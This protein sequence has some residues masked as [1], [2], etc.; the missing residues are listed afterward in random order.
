MK[1]QLTVIVPFFNEEK[2]LKDS[3]T[4][5]TTLNI[6]KEIILVDDCSNDSSLEIAKKLASKFKNIRLISKDQNGGKG[7]C[8]SEVTKHLATSHVIIHDADLEYFPN[9]IVDMFEQ[10][11][12]NKNSLILGS[13]FIGNKKRENVYLRTYL[14]NKVMSLFFSLINFYKISDIATCYKL[15]PTNFLENIDIKEN[16]FSIEV[17]ILSKF[18]KYNKSI[19]EVP[20]SYEG[21]S[22]ADG[23][24]IKFSDGLK[25]I[26]NTLK[27]RIT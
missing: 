4:R 21:R 20:I 10:A 16:G 12:S 23:K 26:I 9:D 7:S 1:I 14:A 11:L 8:I 22:Y 27:Y 13:R 17:E 18:L 2:F 6:F 15:M 3:V 5:L 25:Y 24:K 19:K